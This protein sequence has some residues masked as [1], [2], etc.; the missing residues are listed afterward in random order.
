MFNF[1]YSIKILSH[2]STTLP[3]IQ[4]TLIINRNAKLIIITK[5]VYWNVILNSL[6]LYSNDDQM[7]IKCK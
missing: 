4:I 2:Y 3:N 1:Y 7:M 5:T 6:V